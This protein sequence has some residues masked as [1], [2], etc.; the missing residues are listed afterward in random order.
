MF[1]ATAYAFVAAFAV[2]TFAAMVGAAVHIVSLIR[3]K[4]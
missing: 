2:I 4:G 1:D 3:T